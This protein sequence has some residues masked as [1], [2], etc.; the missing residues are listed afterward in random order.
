M[1]KKYA[2]VFDLDETIGNFVQLGI[3]WDGLK[4][5]FGKDL[6]EETFF[7]L[8][9]T[10][11]NYLRPNIMTIFNYL[12]RKKKKNKNIKVLIYTNNQG[13]REWTEMIKKYIEKKIDYNLFDQIIAA[14]K[15]NGRQVETCRTSHDKS[16]SDFLKCTKMP[17]KTKICFLDDQYHEKMKNK[18]VVYVNLKPYTFNYD[19]TK[20]I[21]M[22]LS[23]SKLKQPDDVYKFK[24]RIQEHISQYKY[25]FQEKSSKESE[26]DKVVTKQ[27]MIHLQEFLKNNYTKKYK[28]INFNYTMKHG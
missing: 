11:A 19:F 5:F 10:F 1:T 8:L 15:V 6:N 26:V 16:V 2:V 18:N 28:T 24:S 9:D 21:D 20:M 7:K 17:K 13:P 27:V 12:K 22:Y 14:Y 4:Q 25:T 23:N 3:F